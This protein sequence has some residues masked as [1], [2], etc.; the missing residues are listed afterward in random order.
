MKPQSLRL[1]L[2]ALA[3]VAIGAALALA[4]AALSLLFERHLERQAQA[5]LERLG[6]VLAAGITVNEAGA[7]RLAAE[8]SDPRFQT[9]GSGLYW[10]LST[11]AS[12][13]TS[14]SLW[15]GVLPG[16]DAARGDA[17]TAVV[18]RGPFEDEVMQV[19]RRIQPSADGAAVLVQIAEDHGAVDAAQ[20]GFAGELGLS[21]AIL[22][23]S[24]L[25]AAWAQ[26]V[27]GLQPLGAVQR[28]LDALRTDPA[29]RLKQADFP[30]E[31]APLADEINKLADARAADMVRARSRAQD[32]AHALK[33]PLTALK[34]QVADLP[35]HLRT[36]LDRSLVVLQQAIGAELAASA[37]ARFD[38]A[39]HCL[40]A[41]VMDRLIAVIGRAHAER[42][43]RITKECAPFHGA[44]ITQDVALELF[45]AVMDNAAKHA[46]A[47]VRIS[48][49]AADGQIQIAIDDDGPGIP[50]DQMTHVVERGARLDQR[51]AGQ[52]LGLAIATDLA[53]S[54]GGDLRL[55]RSALGGLCVRVTWPIAR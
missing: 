29:A 13:L 50:D 17:W 25:A 39:A 10:R 14:R 9:P 37:P 33:T 51:S 4:W 43:V 47:M 24:L 16:A 20:A 8:P 38:S 48:S 27:W 5:D 34:L 31:V 6:G 2:M 22:W 54:T 41:P 28:A 30:A 26:I 1:R 23:A 36:E 52:G 55:S 35:D 18:G 45:G 42:N 40:I 32:L 53:H 3:A 49:L 12:A 21:L 19:M 7:L 15:D 46:R 44:P 11:E